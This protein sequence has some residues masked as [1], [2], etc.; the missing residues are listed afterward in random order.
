MFSNDRL[1]SLYLTFPDLYQYPHI[2]K[3]FRYFYLINGQF[4]LE[5]QVCLC[6][7][8]YLQEVGAFG[9]F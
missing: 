8:P 3:Y 2:L 5:F 7:P 9:S 6:L 4:C 1:L